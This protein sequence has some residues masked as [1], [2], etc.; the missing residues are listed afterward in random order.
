[1]ASHTTGRDTTLTCRLPPYNRSSYDR[2]PLML[3]ENKSPRVMA[4]V[5]AFHRDQARHACFF[6]DGAVEV[7]PGRGRPWVARHH[8][9][10]VDLEN[11]SADWPG[12]GWGS[13][14]LRRLAILADLHEISIFVVARSR[15]QGPD[16][17]ADGTLGQ[18]ALVAFYARR[19]FETVASR[20]GN[21]YMARP[22]RPLDQSG[23][24]TALLDM[25]EVPRWRGLPMPGEIAGCPG[26]NASGQ[27]GRQVGLASQDMQR[28]IGAV[29]APV[30]A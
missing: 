30:L 10:D 8:W 3:D 24:R 5:A 14:A 4:F 28:A 17:P 13:A 23:R 12:R 22:C 19:G 11:L 20:N 29:A 6:A 16:T 26:S 21:T 1:M 15:H 9:G 25:D 27:R 7:W 2:F 18:Q